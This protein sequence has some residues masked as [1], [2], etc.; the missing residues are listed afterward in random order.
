[1]LK[2]FI[3]T[4]CISI[5]AVL[6]MSAFVF[7]EGGVNIEISPVSNYFTI[8]AGDVQLYT[9]TISNRGDTGFKYRLY[10]S[11]YVVADEEYTLNFNEE[12]ATS[13]NQITRWVTFKDK[14]GSFVSEPTFYIDA[15]E[16]QDITY[17]I[18][19]PDDIPEGGQY[20]IVFA[21]TVNDNT[22]EGGI[23]AISRVA[24]S[25][26]GHGM[27]STKDSAEILEY[28][29]S[30]P[31]SREGI[32]ASTRVKNSGNTDFEATY[33]L[34]T[35]SIFGKTLY[36]LSSS[37]T[38]LPETTRKITASWEKAPLFGIFNVT[39]TVSASD[40]YREE[41]HIV[42]IVPIAI[43]VIVILLLTIIAIWI[44]ILIKKRKERSSRLVV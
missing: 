31:F 27:G 15:G 8:K 34:V 2:H 17:R 23:N 20:G 44:I 42:L 29:V 43:L 40:A 6:S 35:K 26:I 4:I 41:S 16:D 7:A 19:V 14:S 9:M 32:S 25:L 38:I 10:T 13:Y 12:A 30:H 22:V 36:D 3:T 24:L 1:M 37:Y 28:S 33:H 39:F 11:P 21:E 5:S 18:S